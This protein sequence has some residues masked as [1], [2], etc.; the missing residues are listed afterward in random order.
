VP[1]VPRSGVELARDGLSE[2]IAQPRLPD[3]VEQPKDIVPAP[4]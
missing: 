3:D 1:K 4:A 2:S